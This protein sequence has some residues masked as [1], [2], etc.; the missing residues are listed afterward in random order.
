[1]KAYLEIKNSGLNFTLLA[2]IL[3]LWAVHVN[4]MPDTTISNNNDAR[5]AA[6]K[7]TTSPI[8]ILNKDFLYNFNGAVPEI[9]SNS[10]SM[11]K[12]T[13]ILD[14]TIENVDMN[15][16][17]ELNKDV[18][19][20]MIVADV[21][22]IIDDIGYNKSQGLAAINIPGN[23]TYAIIPHSPHSKFLATAAHNKQKEI[24]L[25]APMSNIHNHPM[26]QSGLTNDM[27]K[28][29]FDHTLLDAL[30]SV[31]YISGVNNHMGSL[32]TQMQRP[33]EW[34]MKT[35]KENGLYFID[36]RTPP[37]S[38]AWKTA[39][40]FNI[41]SL[42][43]D[44]FLD[45]KRDSI[46]IAEQFE[47]F[48]NIAKRRGYAIAIGHPYPETI[49]YL[50]NNINRLKA[51]GIRLKIASELVNRHSPNKQQQAKM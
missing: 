50:K 9:E 16:D 23:L 20:Q 22:I 48:I 14:D 40:Q 7:S 29:H 49:E 12:H 13:T 37:A 18:G 26:G 25:H 27:S 5:F 39:Q 36:S 24:I 3:Y 47:R 8:T 11:I 4:S 33:M 44:V 10:D 41:A 43:R 31:P 19:P 21:A 45:H 1:M 51:H 15:I 30:A 6:D 46:F 28:E 38:I 32:L 35:I 2:V 42:K 17:I 34:T